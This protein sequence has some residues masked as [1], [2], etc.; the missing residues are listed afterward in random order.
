MF[1]LEAIM[2]SIK[3][4]RF[5]QKIIELIWTF[6]HKSNS[7]KFKFKTHH[8]LR[9]KT[10][11]IEENIP[12]VRLKSRDPVSERTEVQSHSTRLVGEEIRKEQTNDIL[13]RKMMEDNLD[14]IYL[15]YG[16]MSLLF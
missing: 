15:P 2:K 10:P 11:S 6:D 14:M 5:K 4:G 12:E 13:Q 16:Q 1:K 9:K 8:I 3:E 7:C